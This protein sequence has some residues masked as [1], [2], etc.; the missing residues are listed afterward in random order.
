MCPESVSAVTPAFDKLMRVSGI[1]P[2]RAS[3]PVGRLASASEVKP[4]DPSSPLRH[5]ERKSSVVA[6]APAAR[7][8]RHIA[9]WTPGGTGRRS[10]QPASVSERRGDDCNTPPTGHRA[11][12]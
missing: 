3:A 9:A 8:P 7:S 10:R 12:H 5:H 2:M 6:D 11:E 1:T 4:K